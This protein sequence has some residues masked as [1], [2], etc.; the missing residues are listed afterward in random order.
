MRPAVFWVLMLVVLASAWLLT[1]LTK[2]Q[3]RFAPL[4]PPR[5]RP[6]KP[7]P[8]KPTAADLA[9]AGMIN[10]A[11][12]DM[13]SLELGHWFL[14]RV[15]QQYDQGRGCDIDYDAI[16][17]SLPGTNDVTRAEQASRLRRLMGIV[18]DDDD[19]MAKLDFYRKA[20]LDPVN[21]TVVAL[22]KY[23]VRSPVPLPAPAIR[24]SAETDTQSTLADAFCYR[25]AIVKCG[26]YCPNCSRRF[27]FT[28][29]ARTRRCINY[30]P[31]INCTVSAN[32][33]NSLAE[34]QAA[35]KKCPVM[36]TICTQPPAENR[37]T[38]SA[39]KC[40]TP[41]C[42]ECQSSGYSYSAAARACQKS[43][44]DNQ[45]PATANFFKSMAECQAG[46]KQ[47]PSS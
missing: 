9:I 22:H 23:P 32:F 8:R 39:C 21:G 47:C 7:P 6:V 29:D 15:R 31:P 46:T 25:D 19:P 12:H 26:P 30:A 35:S 27:G 28:F 45:C 37:C 24:T 20:A 1:R 17:Q 13:R 18:C 33:F 4:A 40:K 2:K 14:D 43:S 16:V 38:K 5:L 44:H 11:D 36:P 10:A 42:P 3:R 41:G 34:C